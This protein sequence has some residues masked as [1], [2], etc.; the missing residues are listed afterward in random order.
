MKNCTIYVAKTKALISC[1]VTAQLISVFVF[2]DAKNRF[3]H[4]AVH[5]CF[6]IDQIIFPEPPKKSSTLPDLYRLLHTMEEDGDLNT[7]QQPPSLFA[8]PEHVTTYQKISGELSAL[9]EA[10]TELEHQKE[11]ID[12][13]FP[14]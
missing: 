9:F 11:H 8:R 14:A 4:D 10:I 3:S 6:I 12:F 7:E 2:A 1:A 13:K 5:I